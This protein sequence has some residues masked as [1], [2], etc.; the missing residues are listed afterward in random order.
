M[1]DILVQILNN[2]ATTA[3]T[4]TLVAVLI[5][6]VLVIFLNE[7]NNN[8][9]I[10]KR[11]NK[12]TLTVLTIEKTVENLLVREEVEEQSWGYDHIIVFPIEKFVPLL[13]AW[14][15]ETEDLKKVL[16]DNPIG[17]WGSGMASGDVKRFLAALV[18]EGK[19]KIPS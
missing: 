3:L 17:G 6:F 18:E 15:V 14:G 7:E 9:Y 12:E 4:V 11:N 16:Q 13:R 2:V 10:K 19:A 5:F 8:V 1:N